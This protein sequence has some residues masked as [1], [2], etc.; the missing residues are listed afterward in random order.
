MVPSAE[1]LPGKCLIM[2]LT[3]LSAFFFLNANPFT[4]LYAI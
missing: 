3:V 1:K 2:A 4:S